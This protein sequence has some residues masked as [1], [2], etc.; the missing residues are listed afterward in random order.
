[1]V[2][3]ASRAGKMFYSCSR[4]PDCRFASW[5]LPV[6]GPCPVC[7][8]PAMTE[9]TRKGGKTQIVCLRK[10]CKGKKEEEPV[11]GTG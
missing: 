11:A 2:E 5:S 4:Y 6:A 3:R 10:G 7:G 8:Y 1:M 9:K